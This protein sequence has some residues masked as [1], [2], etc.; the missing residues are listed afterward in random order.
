MDKDKMD[1]L[2]LFVIPAIIVML[3]GALNGWK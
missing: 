3:V 1:A 2:V